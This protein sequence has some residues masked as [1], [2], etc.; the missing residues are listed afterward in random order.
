[1]EYIAVFILKS[2]LARNHGSTLSIDFEGL[3]DRIASH[4][5]LNIPNS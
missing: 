1:M 4:V 5:V 3:F 2:L